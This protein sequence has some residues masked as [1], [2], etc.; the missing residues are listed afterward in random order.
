MRA[1]GTYPIARPRATTSDL[2]DAGASDAVKDL[3]LAIVGH[4]LRGPLSTV[5]A[6]ARILADRG[7]LA[8]PAREGVDRILRSGERMRR[9]VEHLL[10]AARARQ[11]GGIPVSPGPV[12]DLRPLVGRII[13]EVRASH[14]DHV[15][16]QRDTGP[17]EA[18]FDEDRMEQV[19]SNLLMNAVVHGDPTEPIVLSVETD[20]ANARLSVHN[21]G[22][23]I[24]PEFM[25][26]L[27]DPFQRAR[28]ERDGSNGLGLGLYIAERIMS[29]H[30]GSMSVTS[31]AEAGTRFVATFPRRS[32]R[33]VTLA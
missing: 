1:S 17:A 29:A 19:V 20:E 18:E 26:L 22:A 8:R 2:E 16:L 3:F 15:I 6:S 32:S 28:G 33:L 24:P 13:D 9:L 10:D 14:P 7:D 25:A 21:H 31:S 27:F 11:P 30:G 12:R 4:D 23:P 5:L